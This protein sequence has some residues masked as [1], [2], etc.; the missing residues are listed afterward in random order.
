MGL[1]NFKASPKLLRHLSLQTLCSSCPFS[2]GL[3]RDPRPAAGHL[4]PSPG[5]TGSPLPDRLS[6]AIPAALPPHSRTNTAIYQTA[7]PD[8]HK[9]MKNPWYFFFEKLLG[10]KRFFFLNLHSSH[11]EY[12]NSKCK[13]VPFIYIFVSSHLRIFLP[14][15]F[16]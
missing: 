9:Y 3:K 2:T 15:H 4:L 10:A 5:S 1:Y 12:G 7:I 13:P 6:A 11:T 16:K 14:F 8:L